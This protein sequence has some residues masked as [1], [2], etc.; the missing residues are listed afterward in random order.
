MSKKL[1]IVLTLFLSVLIGFKAKQVQ[2][3]GD[4]RPSITIIRQRPVEN[5]ADAT[6]Q[7][8]RPESGIVYTVERVDVVAVNATKEIDLS[9]KSSYRMT[10][11]KASEQ[12]FFRLV[13]DNNGYAKLSGADNLPRGYYRITEVGHEK[14]AFVVSL[15]YGRRGAE[16]ADLVVR[17]KSGFE[18]G[19]K[20][21]RPVEKIM[22]TSGSFDRSPFWLLILGLVSAV[23]LS[24]GTMSLLH[25]RRQRA[26]DGKGDRHEIV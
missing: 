5:N 9:D 4:Y 26:Y 8:M 22:Q 16:L 10:S 17:P 18:T 7:T 12:R 15:P 25:A 6:K 21:V 2:A 11:V 19:D 3:A 1:I 24:F 14:S 23:L 20:P 13:T